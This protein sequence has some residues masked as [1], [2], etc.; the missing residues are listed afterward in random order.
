[1]NSSN[2]P[3][4]DPTVSMESFSKYNRLSMETWLYHAFSRSIIRCRPGAPIS[5]WLWVRLCQPEKRKWRRESHI[6]LSL[7]SSITAWDGISFHHEWF[8]AKLTTCVLTISSV[9]LS[10][11]TRSYMHAEQFMKVIFPNIDVL[12]LDDIH[13][14]ACAVLKYLNKHRNRA[15]RA[16]IIS[17]QPWEY[18][19]NCSCLTLIDVS[20]TTRRWL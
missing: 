19:I 13:Y 3:R 4:G 10:D 1:M 11:T 12:L 17:Q 9:F 15:S 2:R 7:E 5:I 6:S 18:A 16:C 14:I 8:H 20:Y